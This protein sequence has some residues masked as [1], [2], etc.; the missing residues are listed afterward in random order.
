LAT[1]QHFVTSVYHSSQ[2]Q[3]PRYV[4]CSSAQGFDKMTWHSSQAQAP[5]YVSVQV[6]KVLTRWHGTRPLS[7]IRVWKIWKVLRAIGLAADSKYRLNLPA[8]LNLSIEFP[9][10]NVMNYYIN[11][12]VWKRTAQKYTTPERFTLRKFSFSLL[13]AK[14]KARSRHS[15]SFRDRQVCLLGSN[16]LD[17]TMFWI[18]IL[19]S[20][21]WDGRL[22]AVTRRLILSE[23]AR[24]R[25]ADF[26]RWFSPRCLLVK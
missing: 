26:R 11:L 5:T 17:M 23:E 3:A 16:I 18:L 10:F 8:V 4:V 12:T 2:A 19:F 15:P 6:H 25:C 7:F 1:P 20:V 21:Y 22:G 13:R 14:T 9:I 24:N